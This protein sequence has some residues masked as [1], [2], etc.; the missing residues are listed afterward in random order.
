[1][2]LFGFV[3]CNL[4]TW[5]ILRATINPTTSNDFSKEDKRDNLQLQFTWKIRKLKKNQMYTMNLDFSPMAYIL[6]FELVN[7]CLIMGLII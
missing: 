2:V 1:M 3:S 5:N 4:I 6:E 7:G